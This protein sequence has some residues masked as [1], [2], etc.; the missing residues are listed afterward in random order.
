M[1]SAGRAWLSLTPEPERDLPGAVASLRLGAPAPAELREEE[2]RRLEGL[3]VGS[4]RR[5]FE[6]WLAEARALALP[7]A[8]SEPGSELRAAA[9]LTLDVIDNHDAL[10]RGLEPRGGT[11]R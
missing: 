11:S 8:A 1:T 3:I 6:R 5:A 7:H 4:R 9:R 2:R 10:R